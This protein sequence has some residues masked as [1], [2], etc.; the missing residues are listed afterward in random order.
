MALS[1][2]DVWAVGF[3][4]VILYYDGQGWSL[5]HSPTSKNLNSISLLAPGDGWI[6]GDQGTLLHYQNQS[7]QQVASPTSETLYSVKML[8]TDEGWA[9]G[10]N[11]TVLH[12]RAGAWY[13]VGTPGA[14]GIANPG[15]ST[16][17]HSFYDVTMTSV[18]SGW[19]AS[20]NGMVLY[21]HE[22]WS[23]S[24]SG[25]FAPNSSYIQSDLILY[26]VNMLSALDGWAVGEQNQDI[27]LFHYQ[28]GAWQSYY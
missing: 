26:G 19:I 22:V 7:W 28:D 27:L 6:V 25:V 21:N 3:G 20:A 14:F 23:A 2:N 24:Q 5:V 15:G 10:A 12:N 8:S 17:L 18:R 13:T 16:A 1:A 11:E 4:G 9:V